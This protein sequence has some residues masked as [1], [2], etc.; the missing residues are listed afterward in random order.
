MPLPAP[1]SSTTA[2]RASST[3][4]PTAATANGG[5]IR[6]KPG[7]PLAELDFDD[8]AYRRFKLTPEA[9]EDHDRHL[10]YWDGATNTAIEVRDVSPYHE[11][12]SHRLAALAE[13]VA[14]V[15]GHPI[16]CFGTMS[17]VL[18][19]TPW[20]PKRLMEADQSL[21]LHPRRTNLVGPSSMNV[22]EHHYP[23]VVLEV[24]LSTDVR[25]NK[26]MLYEAWG[27]PEL[28]VDVPD[29]ARRPRKPRGTTIYILEGR[30]LKEAG[31]SLA[32]P[33]WRAKDI[34]LALNEERLS[35]RTVA[36]LERI[37][38]TLGE[39]IGTGPDDDPMLG[40]LRQQA[41]LEGVVAGRQE[42]LKEALASELA[43][44][45]SMVRYV[46]KA[47]G[48]DVAPDFPLR[49]PGFAEADLE[50]LMAAATACEDEADFLARVPGMGGT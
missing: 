38:R 45:A 24:D 33:G 18:P 39:R 10:E 19:E 50:Q 15:R 43:R 22:G 28:W 36:N 3:A 25:R 37:G 41:R 31:E 30:T 5:P 44:R 2:R 4:R 21:Y 13:R 8:P 27:F 17:L 14:Q 6:P 48:V 11:R 1:Q 12:P 35:A 26:L 46:M 20:R 42:G 29:Q 16:T 47:R 32:F 49:E 23:D 7:P 40:A 9:L 34:H